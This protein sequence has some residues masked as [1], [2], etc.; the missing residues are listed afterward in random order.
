[1]VFSTQQVIDIAGVKDGVIIMKDGSYRLIMQVAAINFALKSEQEQNSLVFQYQSFIN[2]LHF[3][4]E[5]VIRSRRLDLAPYLK[6]LG[7]KTKD[8]KNELIKMQTEDYVDFVG[9]LINMANIM[10]KTFYAVVS[11]NPISVKQTGIFDRFFNKG[12][13]FDHLKISDSEFKN[14]S[15]KLTERAN[16][17]ASGLGG[18][19]L[20]CFQ[21]STE[22]I[23]ELFYQIYNPDEAAKERVTDAASLSS[24]VVVSEDE[25]SHTDKP[26]EGQTENV[27]DNSQIVVAQR[28]QE[29][30][31]RRQE[32]D[33]A[34]EREMRQPTSA[35]S[36]AGAG[37][38]AGAPV[39]PGQPAAVAGIPPI[40][41][42][43]NLPGQ[44]QP[45][46]PITNATPPINP[47]NQT[48]QSN[49]TSDDNSV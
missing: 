39:T 12:Q 15:E 30:E 29:A 20:H 36:V 27:I 6:K 9:K 3:P 19:G 41:Q 28:K 44:S 23:I 13:V 42:S 34:A 8:Q 22:E 43:A 16:I 5:V 26:K 49:K 38:T 48:K 33:K 35:E 24:P 45:A 4:L 2:S 21:L 1:M 11:H 7:D 46:T 32:S 10:K 37:S 18:M 47:T 31:M 17:V 25:V 40:V 14:H